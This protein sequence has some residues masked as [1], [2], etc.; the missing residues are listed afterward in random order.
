MRAGVQRHRP[1]AGAV[2]RRPF[3]KGS[4]PADYAIDGTV[5]VPAEGWM[6]IN[7]HVDFQAGPG[8]SPGLKKA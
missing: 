1:H 7:N 5:Q 4:G 3:A 2:W 8:H 6:T